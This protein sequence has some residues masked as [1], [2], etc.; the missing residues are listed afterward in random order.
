MPT[1]SKHKDFNSVAV[2]KYDS[3]IQGSLNY[4]INLIGGFNSL[5]IPIIIKPNICSEVDS[6]GGA[7]TRI[8]LIRTLLD[9]ILI[10]EEKT[11][12]R[13]VESDSTGKRIENAFKR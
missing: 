12:I 2:V 4:G 13:I 6:S 9:M 1:N 7:T 10:K 5:G 8:D 11:R 3:D